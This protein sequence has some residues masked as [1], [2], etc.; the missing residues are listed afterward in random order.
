MS[1]INIKRKNWLKKKKRT[2]KSLGSLGLYP[3]LIVF[4]SN[5]HIYSQ[6]VDDNKKITVLSASSIDKEFNKTKCTNKSDL[7]KQIGYSIAEKMKKN[8]INKIIFDRN[9]YLY[10]GRIK[11]LAEAI[12]EKGIQI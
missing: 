11:V 3:R 1:K 12:R 10:H 8:K 4:K 5:R 7:S 9:G 2:K 6:L